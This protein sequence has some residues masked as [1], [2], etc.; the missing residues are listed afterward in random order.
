MNLVHICP[1]HLSPDQ[2]NPDQIIFDQMSS[3]HLN[4]DHPG[5]DHPG[6]NRLSL[7]TK[8]VRRQ[9][10]TVTG[11]PEDVDEVCSMAEELLHPSCAAGI[12]PLNTLRGSC[13]GPSA[14]VS[15]IT[16][17][18]EI[19]NK[20]DQMMKS[21][22]YTEG[23]ILDIF[24]SCA[25]FRLAEQVSEKAGRIPFFREGI[26]ELSIP[27]DLPFTAQKHICSF[28]DAENTLG[29]TLS[30]SCMFIPEKT[31]SQ[32]FIGS[33][34]GSSW[35]DVPFTDAACPL[36]RRR[37]CPKCSSSGNCPFEVSAYD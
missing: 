26:R 24:S 3:D 7:D 25:L 27:E 11:L 6:L 22:R 19:C 5:L 16:L 12:I 33:C 21:G 2:M 8:A 34:E 17:G 20:I 23:M 35:P 31:M 30:D 4:L 18:R 10:Y 28:L 32:C 14:V 13:G 15:I 29:V 37:V 9:L 36:T 1:D